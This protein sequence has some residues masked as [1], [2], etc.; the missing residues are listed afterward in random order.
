MILDVLFYHTIGKLSKRVNVM[1]ILCFFVLLISF[2]CNIGASSLRIFYPFLFL[3]GACVLSLRSDDIKKISFLFLPSIIIGILGVIYSI[4]TD[5][6]PNDFSV[7]LEGKNFLFPVGAVGFSPTPQVYGTFC[8]LYIWVC[9]ERKQL[10]WGFALSVIG[11]L[12]SMNRTSY[13]FFLFILFLYKRVWAVLAGVCFL[14]IL[15]NNVDI[16]YNLTDSSNLDSRDQLRYGF[17]MHYWQSKDLL[18]L[19]IGIGNNEIAPQYS[20]YNLTDRS[21]IENG[22]DF[23]LAISGMIG[24]IFYMI[25]IS[26]FVLKLLNK[27]KFKI[28]LVFLF[29]MFVNQWMT[30]EFLASSFFFFIL[31]VLVM[32][33]RKKSLL[34]MSDSVEFAIS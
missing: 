5:F 14:P 18:T 2:L 24:F 12:L 13:V 25:F 9:F 22:L 3:F 4:M 19:L 34:A 7:Y 20:K 33:R 11:I 28:C 15:L 27:R 31:F 30:Q 21:Y 26:L 17:E 23:I 6:T 8:I 10:D 16:L 32:S 29:Y 1:L